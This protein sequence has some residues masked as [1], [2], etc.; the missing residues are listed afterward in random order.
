MR[1]VRLTVN[2]RPVAEAIDERM[3]LADFLR[4]KLTLT[5]THLRCE[6]GV[7]GACTLLI[8]G[9]PVRSCITWAALCDGAD[10]TTLEGLEH[11]PVIATLRSAFIAEHGLQCGFCTPGMLI[12]ARDIVARLPDADDARVRLE[13]SGNLCRCTGYAGIVGAIRRVLDARK[14]DAPALAPV[15]ERLGPVG[16]RTAQPA[17]GAGSSAIPLS[18]REVSP[19]RLAN[20]RAI[21][22]GSAAPNITLRQSFTVARPPEE[23]WHML[24]D[25]AR[26]ASFM[27]GAV[28]TGPIQGNRVPARMTVKLGPIT[29]TFD[30]E[31]EIA[32][33]DAARRGRIAGGG[34]DRFTRSRVAAELAYTVGPNPGG[35]AGARVDIDVHALLT[36]PLAQFNRGGIVEEVA[37]RLT[38]MFAAN[39][40]HAMAGGDAA[41][42]AGDTA[43]L[44]AGALIGGALLARLRA[45]LKRMFGRPGD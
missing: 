15:R 4:E 16:A 31:A 41:R 9:E 38:G 18:A 30:G 43:P 6:Q 42:P 37:V 3:H 17:A 27:P 33:D 13:L 5:A 45:W 20:V 32:R 39:L 44:G 19:A 26:V 10:I 34:Q 29:A 7:C 11:D 28:L 12:T 36:G 8:D 14:A 2:G 21:G 25:I 23:V 35:A 1:T 22:L 40:E 24:S